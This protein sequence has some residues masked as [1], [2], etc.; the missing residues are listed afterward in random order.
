[1]QEKSQIEVQ[2]IDHL[3]IIDE[4][5]MVEIIDRELVK[6]PQEKVS[7]GQ[8]VKAM[9]LNCMGFLTAPLYL[10]SEFFVGKA[11][12][13]LIGEGVKAEYLNNSRL[14]R[15]MD[16]LYE[17]GLTH[18]NSQKLIGMEF[19]GEALNWGCAPNPL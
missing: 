6:Y 1:M 12:E 10:F 16:R 9:I 8:V 19:E 13:H 17:L 3:G 11:T 2:D 15:V 14:R 4:I 18:S 5:G 7:A